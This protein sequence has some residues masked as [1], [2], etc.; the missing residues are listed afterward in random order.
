MELDGSLVRN[1]EAALASAKRLRG[2]RVYPDTVSYW[3]ELVRYARG[4][5][6]SR[7]TREMAE[8]RRLSEQLMAEI[9][10]RH[11]DV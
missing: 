1:L 6:D 5:L 10:R 7:R 9:D 3:L 11:P 4:A 2:K 8:V